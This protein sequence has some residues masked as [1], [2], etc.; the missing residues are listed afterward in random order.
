MLILSLKE[1]MHLKKLTND[2]HWHMSKHSGLKYIV[3]RIY[4]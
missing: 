4:C 2:S 1:Y 3:C